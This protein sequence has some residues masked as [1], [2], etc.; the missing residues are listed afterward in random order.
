MNSDLTIILLLKD[1]H[2]FN[3]RFLN[4]F[5]ENNI[6]H[7]LIISDG[8]KKKID[9]KLSRKIKKNSLIKYF[10]F[11]ED[12]SYKLFYKKV[13]NTVKIVKT[14]YIIFAANDDFLIYK[15]LN[16]C[17]KFLKSNRGFI[18][19]G[20][21]MIG[22]KIFKERQ[23]KNKLTNF[24]DLYK[25]IKLDHK[26]N[27]KRFN[28]F[29]QNYC[30][31]PRNC[32]MKKDILFQ[33]YKFSSNLFGNNIEFKDHFTALFN[34]IS[35]RIKIFKDPLILHQTHSNSENSEGSLRANILKSIFKNENFLNDLTH[36]DRILSKKL[37]VKKNY[38]LNKYYKYVL[39]SLLN[40]FTLIKE[41]SIKQMK[42]IVIKK[43]QR[44]ILN[45][46]FKKETYIEKIKLNK[47]TKRTIKFIE[48]N[49]IN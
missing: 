32:I 3:E 25:Y 13:F 29:I 28:T 43:F 35:G 27:K 12:K 10:K 17:L 6:N 37:R 4:Y 46:D 19:A 15:N 48:N 14:K 26:N 1:R 49:I 8:S 47:E 11:K 22:F 24:Y 41:P 21:T 36:F 16:K 45:K 34:V 18:G 31:L 44:K 39:S 2:E 7:N 20:G 5:N 30:D 33:N 42:N 23:K 38:I 40:A 9:N